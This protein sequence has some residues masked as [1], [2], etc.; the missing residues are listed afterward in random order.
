[1]K[2]ARSDPG[3]FYVVIASAKREAISRMRRWRLL[4]RALRSSQ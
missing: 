3:R 4:R 2:A 1:M